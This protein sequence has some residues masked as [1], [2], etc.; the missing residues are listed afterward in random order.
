MSFEIK[1]SAALSA[2]S[3]FPKPLGFKKCCA[4]DTFDPQ[5]YFIPLASRKFRGLHP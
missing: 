4:I 2:L 5:T 3:S 1:K